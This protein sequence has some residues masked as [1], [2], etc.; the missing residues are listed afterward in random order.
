MVFGFDTVAFLFTYIK[1]QNQKISA[2][3]ISGLDLTS[4]CQTLEKESESAK[5]DL[6]IIA[7]LLIQTNAN[8]RPYGS[9][10]K[11]L[12]PSN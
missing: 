1:E 9:L 10:V 5:A 8:I 6:E 3:S 2:N 4:L 12:K 11:H 7:W